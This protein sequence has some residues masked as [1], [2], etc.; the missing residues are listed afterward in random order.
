MPQGRSAFAAGRG[1]V[2][3]LC[4]PVPPRR[5]D[6]PQLGAYPPGTETPGGEPRHD[7]RWRGAPT[8]PGAPPPRESEAGRAGPG[9][10]RRAPA[11]GRVGAGSWA[12]ATGGRGRGRAHPRPAAR[13][14]LPAT[15]CPPPGGPEPG[16]GWG[17]RW[18][19]ADETGGGGVAGVGCWT[20]TCICGAYSRPTPRSTA[21]AP[22]IYES[23]ALPR[24]PRTRHPPHQANR[25]PPPSRVRG[26]PG[27][28]P[29][30]PEAPPAP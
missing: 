3:G 24:R 15:G 1:P 8:P 14:W 6:C 9:P 20:M 30:P 19:V 23:R 10:P 22:K 28:L 11:T 18:G 7:D 29:P 26:R 25:P 13:H 21:P 12:G 5:N 4:P 16:R 2:G 27:V 17:H